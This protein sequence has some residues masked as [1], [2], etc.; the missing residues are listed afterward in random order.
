MT[1]ERTSIALADGLERRLADPSIDGVSRRGWRS[2]AVV[3]AVL[4]IL[5]LVAM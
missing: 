3:V 5:A 4:A 1:L 2:L